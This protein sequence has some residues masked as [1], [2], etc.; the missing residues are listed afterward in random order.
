[1]CC[2]FNQHL[3]L[4]AYGWQVVVGLGPPLVRIH[5]AWP[6]RD[7]LA[8]VENLRCRLAGYAYIARFEGVLGAIEAEDYRLRPD[9]AEYKRKSA[10]L[11]MGWSVLA[12]ALTNRR[13]PE[14]Q[15]LVIPAS[16]MAAAR[17]QPAESKL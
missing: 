17:V 6:G 10:A 15:E 2:I 4:R 16:Q 7:Y 5:Q 14:R 9:Y 3:S 8:Q 13:Q 1:M 11:Q 12:L